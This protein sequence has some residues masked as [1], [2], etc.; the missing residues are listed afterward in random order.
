MTPLQ[1]ARAFAALR[2]NGSLP[3]LRIVS[4]LEQPG[5]SWVDIPAEIGARQTVSPAATASVLRA[6]A[7][8]PGGFAAMVASA[9]TG[10]GGKRVNW[11]V[12]ASAEGEPGVVVVVVL[13]NGTLADAWRIGR[14]ALAEA[15]GAPG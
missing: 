7:G 15:I 1:V 4:G 9:L 2:S 13:E 10:G 11:F 14:Q 3:L 12:G 5:G 6:L 8:E